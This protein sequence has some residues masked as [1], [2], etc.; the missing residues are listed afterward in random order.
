M[1]EG[2]TIFKVA[3]LLRGELTGST[4]QQGR[5]RD[6]PQVR[7]DGRRIE[8][9]YAHGKH[10]FVTFDDG[11]ILRSH[12][13]MFGSWHRYRSGEPWRRPRR[14][15]AIE[16][17]L[18]R[19][20]FVC[21]NAKEVELLRG[22][23]VRQRQIHTRLGQDLLARE[24]D[25]KGILTRAREFLEPDTLVVDLLLDQRVAAGIGN[26]YKSEILFLHRVDPHR[27]LLTLEDPLIEGMY[28]TARSLL[29][30]NLGGGPRVTRFARDGAGWHWVYHRLGMPCFHCGQAVVYERMGKTW[31]GTYWC[32]R[33]QV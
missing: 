18:D 3:E 17:T 10:L 28:G 7:L 15:A 26:A 27:S 30:K 6:R 16:L 24:V 1:P 8:E 19:D 21:F 12:L 22:G 9:V 14:Q 25:F 5:L 13:G 2:D 31:R 20:V 11:T 4:L 33:C 23:S 32:P 29:Q